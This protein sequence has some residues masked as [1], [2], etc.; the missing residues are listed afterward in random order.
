MAAIPAGMDVWFQ[1][2]VLEKIKIRFGAAGAIAAGA[3][4]TDSVA[5]ADTDWVVAF[6]L[7]RQA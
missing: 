2:F 7:F 1:P 5:D 6:W 3:A 4:A